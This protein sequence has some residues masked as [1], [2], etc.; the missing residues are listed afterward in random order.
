MLATNALMDFK[1]FSGMTPGDIEK[2][3]SIGRKETYENE[4]IIFEDSSRDTDLF[5][6]LDGSVSVEIDSASAEGGRK[7]RIQLT[8][9]RFGDV[10]G[11]IAFL[12]TRRRSASVRSVGKVSILRINGPNLYEFFDQ[13]KNMGYL[14]MK[15]L[16]GI[17]AQRLIETNFKLRDSGI[18][19]L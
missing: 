11:E 2:I 8:T 17:L 18:W 7:K 14:M 16:A 4:E 6:I 9:L 1:L 19:H 10:F 12:A 13:E 15:N 3:L 5:L